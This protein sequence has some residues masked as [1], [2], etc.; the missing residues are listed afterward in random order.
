MTTKDAFL[1]VSKWGICIL[2]RAQT[3][4]WQWGSNSQ[5]SDLESCTVPREHTSLAQCKSVVSDI[6]GE[7]EFCIDI[8]NTYTNTQFKLYTKSQLKLM[9]ILE[10]K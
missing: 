1:G 9:I 4:W 5:A 8:E 2:P 7:M 3:F 10:Q 6:L